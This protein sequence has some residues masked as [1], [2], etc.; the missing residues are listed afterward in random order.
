MQQKYM[1]AH[2]TSGRAFILPNDAGRS[3]RI[4]GRVRTLYALPALAV[5]KLA[6][7]GGKV[8]KGRTRNAQTKRPQTLGPF[9]NQFAGCRRL[10]G[11]VAKDQVSHAGV[12]LPDL[13]AAV[14]PGDAEMSVPLNLFPVGFQLVL[15]AKIIK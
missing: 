3:S 1:A 13:N 10:T 7:L 8:R 6:A 4:C 9:R 14:K 5:L 2:I 15:V 11:V 12:D